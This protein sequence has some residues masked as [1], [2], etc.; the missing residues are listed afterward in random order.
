MA[1]FVDWDLA[2]ATAAALGKSGP[3]ASYEEAAEAVADLRGLAEEA[4][5]HVSSFTG[6][7]AQLA[8]PP[9]RVVDRRD[10]ASTNIDGLRQV[11]DPLAL[12]AHLATAWPQETGDRAQH[13]RLASAVGAHHRQRLAGLDDHIHA[14]QRWQVAVGDVDGGELEQAHDS[15]PR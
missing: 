13:R 9:V 14:A 2:A 15:F 3:A 12:K 7:R 4:A 1:Q 11:V 5:E 8:A 6:L 10:W